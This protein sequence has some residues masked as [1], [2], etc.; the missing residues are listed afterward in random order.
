MFQLP[1]RVAYPMDRQ[2]TGMCCL[3][4]TKC[5][6]P[7]CPTVSQEE[8]YKNASGS[9]SE[10][11]RQEGTCQAGITSMLNSQGLWN[12]TKIS[13][14]TQPQSDRSAMLTTFLSRAFDVQLQMSIAMCSLSTVLLLRCEC[15]SSQEKQLCQGMQRRL[16][17]VS[18]E[19]LMD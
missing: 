7:C 16:T 19:L 15:R 12:W 18:I 13:L 8:I 4:D 6:V 1:Y 9:A 17:E 10:G 5:C 2:P 11:K 14:D 3:Y